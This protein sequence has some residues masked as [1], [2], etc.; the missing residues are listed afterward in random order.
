IFD[1]VDI[2]APSE[3]PTGMNELGLVIARRLIDVLGGTVNLETPDPHGLK[4]TIE[5]PGRPM[6]KQ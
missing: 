1:P 6:E 5:L 3:R 2:E 4:V